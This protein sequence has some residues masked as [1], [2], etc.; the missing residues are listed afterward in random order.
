VIFVSYKLIMALAGGG[1]EDAETLAFAAALAVQHRAV[2]HV[3]PIHPDA[4]VDL[5]A[6]GLTL[7]APLSPEVTQVLA[8]ASDDCQGRIETAARDAAAAVDLVLGDG[9][10]G[11]RLV[12][13]PHSVMPTEDLARALVLADLVIIGQGFLRGPGRDGRVLGQVLLDQRTP[14][15]IARGRPDRLAG[16]VAIAWN[17]SVEAGRAAHGALPLIA[18]GSDLILLQ[19]PRGDVEPDGITGMAALNAWLRLHGAGSGRPV[20]VTGPSAGAALVK[21]ARD[22]DVGLLVA[23][24]WGHSRLRE[25]IFG[26]A[27]R[28]L[29]DDTD[30]PSLLLAH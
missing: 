15:L 25:A 21:G 18:M 9:E 16:R 17:G 29:L 14:L 19:C 30:G 6:L 23:G 10:G 8:E 26:G 28:A 4:A 22:H 27:T 5:V 13:H 20:P 2:A 7:G 12:V 3:L 1:P 11:P 24:A